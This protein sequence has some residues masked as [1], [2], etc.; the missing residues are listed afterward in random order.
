MKPLKL[1][2]RQNSVISTFKKVICDSLKL[3]IYILFS[4]KMTSDNITIWIRILIWYLNNISKLSKLRIWILSQRCV[5]FC[6]HNL[7]LCPH[8]PLSSQHKHLKKM[9]FECINQLKKSKVHWGL[10]S[11]RNI[12]YSTI[13]WSLTG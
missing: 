1:N 9:E 3:Q 7:I 11:M 13:C 8:S 5:T 6:Y 4:Q 2:K 10:E 12:C